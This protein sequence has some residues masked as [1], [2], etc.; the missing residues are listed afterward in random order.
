MIGSWIEKHGVCSANNRAGKFG[1]TEA[2]ASSGNGLS[3]NSE[4]RYL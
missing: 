3:H 4:L 2:M 1:A